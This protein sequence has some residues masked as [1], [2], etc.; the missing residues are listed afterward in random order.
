MLRISISSA[1]LSDFKLVNF[2]KSYAR[3]RKAVF[4]SEHIV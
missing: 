3:K 4:F 1:V 2:L